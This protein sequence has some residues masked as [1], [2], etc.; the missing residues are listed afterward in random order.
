MSVVSTNISSYS[1]RSMNKGGMGMKGG[2]MNQG[3][4]GGSM[5]GR[6]SMASRSGGAAMGASQGYGNDG[7]DSPYPGGYST[8]SR[9]SRNGQSVDVGSTPTYYD[10]SK[11]D[12]GSSYDSYGREKSL[13]DAGVKD[14]PSSALGNIASYSQRRLKEIDRYVYEDVDDRPYAPRG[15]GYKLPEPGST[16]G[17][18]GDYHGDDRRRPRRGEEYFPPPQRR[19]RRR[20]DYRRD[21][22]YEPRPRRSG[23]GYDESDGYENASMGRRDSRPPRQPR[24]PDDSYAS[25]SYGDRKMNSYDSEQRESLRAQNSYGS[26]RRGMDDGYEN[27]YYDE[28]DDYDA[29]RGRRRRRD[30]Y[31][32]YRDDRR[33]DEPPRRRER[34]GGMRDRYEDDYYEGPPRRPPRRRLDPMDSF[35]Y[36]SRDRRREG[37][38][39]R[40]S[41]HRGQPGRRGRGRDRIIDVE[42]RGM[43]DDDPYY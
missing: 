37:I 39:S 8:G 13:R 28:R 20:D 15:G 30:D 38:R 36:D 32:E 43:Y 2:G 11:G 18:D 4:M 3:S 7:M 22:M 34:R 27:D 16:I 40:R 42:P 35:G 25:S 31:D 24:I 1:N 41:G 29:P 21:D 9:S 23:G 14:E 12:R 33:Y 17:V 6:G 26:R 10:Y 19:S 5:G